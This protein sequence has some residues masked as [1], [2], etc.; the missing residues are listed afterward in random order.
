MLFR[1]CMLPWLQPPSDAGSSLA[2]FSTLK[3]EA[4]C[5]SETLVHTRSTRRHIPEDGILYIL[6]CL[7]ILSLTCYSVK[8][9]AVTVCKIKL[10]VK[11]YCHSLWVCD[12]R[13]GMDWILD[14]LTTCIHDSELHVTVH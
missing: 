8:I 7:T 1:I 3:M 9:I 10:R 5:F 14:L 2:D 13:Q 11:I 4:I 6:F 12:Y